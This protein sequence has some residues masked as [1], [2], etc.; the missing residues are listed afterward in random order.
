MAGPFILKTFIFKKFQLNYDHRPLPVPGVA[1]HDG[2][3]PDFPSANYTVESFNIIFLG[4]S[5]TYGYGLRDPFTSFPF[6]T[7]RLLK[8]EYPKMK[9]NVANFGWSASSPILHLRQLEQIGKKYNPDLIIQSFDITDISEDLTTISRFENFGENLDGELTIFFALKV[10]LSL[11][12]EMNDLNHWINQITGFDALKIE[13][14]ALFDINDRKTSYFFLRN[15]LDKTKPYFKTT[16]NTIEKTADLAKSM[17]ANYILFILPRYQHY[18]KNQ[19]LMVDPEGTE[20]GAFPASDQYIFE[21]FRFFEQYGATSPFPVHSLLPY[22]QKT[23]LFPTVFDDNLH[24]NENGHIVSG[25]AIAGYLIQNSL[26][27][28]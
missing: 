19:C 4:D 25:Q 9:I 13:R 18:N 2:V 7:E 21:I 8:K 14:G 24:Y 20:G 22:F 1:N 5:F 28:E 26:I 12:F 11:L 23:E 16:T 15:D 6:V 10:W 27:K 3:M 17:G